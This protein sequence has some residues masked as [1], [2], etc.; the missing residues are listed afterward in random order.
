MAVWEGGVGPGPGG[1]PWGGTGWGCGEG[2]AAVLAFGEV[3]SPL[4]AAYF[5]CP[6][7]SGNGALHGMIS[8]SATSQAP[9]S[10]PGQ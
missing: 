6:L 1:L 8:G 3:T 7:A 10:I 2:L 9:V 5:P 4:C